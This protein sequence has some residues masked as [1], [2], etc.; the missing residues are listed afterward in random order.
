M[1][2][3]KQSWHY[4]WFR[5]FAT[6]WFGKDFETKS[7][8]EYVQI[9]VLGP[10]IFLVLLPFILIGSLVCLAIDDE[11]LPRNQFI[12]GPLWNRLR[13]GFL[14]PLIILTLFFLLFIIYSQAIELFV[15]FGSMAVVGLSIAVIF[16]IYSSLK[17]KIC[18][19]I[20]YV[21]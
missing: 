11:P 4:R 1:K 2:I 18:P 12:D 20:E 8:C 15:V 17:E 10:C 7:F 19:I 6:A 14:V 9:C 5:M 3:H 16:S 13:I 21:E